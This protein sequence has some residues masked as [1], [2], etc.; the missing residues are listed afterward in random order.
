MPLQYL[1]V[2]LQNLCFQ[3]AQLQSERFY[4]LADDLGEL[5]IFF[6]CHELKQ[7]FQT[8]PTNRSYDAE[9]CEMTTDRIDHRGLLPDQQ[10][11]YPMQNHPT[12]LFDRLRR[13]K[14]HVGPPH[15]L[16]DR[17]G[18]GAIVLLPFDIRLDVGRRDQPDLM[19]ESLQL[20][21]PVV[22]GRTGLDSN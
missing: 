18:I 20:A 13:H 12:L 9:L 22:R 6:S 19:T 7:R 15:R 5:R 3:R 1:S 10:A 21:R 11:P 8:I 16:A 14:P 17:F 2:E 4:R